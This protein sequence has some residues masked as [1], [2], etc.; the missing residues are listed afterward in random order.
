MDVLDPL[1]VLA[2][3]GW[4]WG[5]AKKKP[6]AECST[7]GLATPRAPIYRA[8]NF[9]FQSRS[10]LL[11]KLSIDL[12][13]QITDYLPPE[14][15]AALALTCK[16][17]RNL[18]PNAEKQLTRESLKPF[19]LLM[20]RY[21]A[22]KFFYC[23]SCRR[24]HRY[25]KAWKLGTRYDPSPDHWR[26]LDRIRSFG[27]ISIRFPD[28]RLA[29]NKFHL[30]PDSGIDLDRLSASSIHIRTLYNNGGRYPVTEDNEHWSVKSSARIIQGE[31]FVRMSHELSLKGG[32]T[33]RRV[34]LL[35]QHKICQHMYMDDPQGLP[36]QWMLMSA[37]AR[38]RGEWNQDRTV[39]KYE[40]PGSCRICLMDYTFYW[41]ERRAVD[42]QRSAEL[43][44]VA[45]YVE[46]V[47][48]HQ[49]G[50]GRDPSCWKWQ[51]FSK[52]PPYQVRRKSREHPRG[53]V[54]SKWQEWAG[55]E[56][57]AQI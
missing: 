20:E 9:I 3:M 25:R 34:D 36:Q 47:A 40:V 22:V 13:L 52:L 56:G 16:T 1:H 18:L 38:N 10:K 33:R 6:S 8:P 41:E 15:V 31:L 50:D 14:S 32:W 26:C 54:L 17:T 55:A 37:I 48:Y 43:Q 39:Y 12:V 57:G 24:L 11:N 23:H 28:V 30:S 51:T 19:L 7:I 27:P 45:L 53:A 21:L 5:K 2:S 29:T 44:H 35:D 42:P 4:A 46:I 49:L